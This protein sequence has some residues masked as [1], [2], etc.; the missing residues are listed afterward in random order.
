[1]Q[2]FTDAEIDSVYI[3]YNEFKSVLTQRVT[4]K[5]ILPLSVASGDAQPVRDFIYEQ[6]PAQLMGS[7]LP[8]YV[9]LQVLEAFLENTAA[10]HAARMTAMDAATNNA[11]DVMNKLTLYINR[12]RQASIT[13][14]IIEVVSGAAAQG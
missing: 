14:E 1:M 9:L 12:V 7:L 8:R 13:R 6:P 11:S 3:L 5:K 4:L 2:R 10:E